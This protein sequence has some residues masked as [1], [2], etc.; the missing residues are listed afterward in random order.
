[1]SNRAPPPQPVVLPQIKLFADIEHGVPSPKAE[2][3][4]SSDEFCD[5]AAAFASSGRSAEL[6]HM[7]LGTRRPKRGDAEPN[8]QRGTLGGQRDRPSSQ[9]QNVGSNK[10]V[11]QQQQQEWKEQVRARH[12]SE[13]EQMQTKTLT[14][15][16]L[17]SLPMSG[18]TLQPTT[19]A[20]TEN[21]CTS[22]RGDLMKTSQLKAWLRNRY[23]GMFSAAAKKRLPGGAATATTANK[24]S[25][26]CS[27]LH[28]ESADVDR[29]VGR[30][31]SVRNPSEDVEHRADADEVEDIGAEVG[32]ASA[33]KRLAGPLSLMRACC[34]SGEMD[35]EIL[36]LV[37]GMII[38]WWDTAMDVLVVV[39]LWLTGTTVPAALATAFVSIPILA[40]AA[41]M[42]YSIWKGLGNSYVTNLWRQFF[43]I[44][45]DRETG[46]GSKNI[47]PR[48]GS[49]GVGSS[50]SGR[51]SCSGSAGHHHTRGLSA[52]S[53]AG[54]MK[55]TLMR[56]V[57]RHP[58]QQ[59][60]SGS[61]ARPSLS[62]VPEEMMEAGEGTSSEL[63]G[64]AMTWQ[65]S[66][67]TKA[68]GR[69]LQSPGSNSCSRSNTSL[70]LRRRNSSAQMEGNSFLRTLWRLTL[71]WVLLLL[72]PVLLSLVVVVLDLCT[73]LC[74][75]KMKAAV[76]REGKY[77]KNQRSRFT[78][79]RWEIWLKRHALARHPVRAVLQ[80]VPMIVLQVT[81]LALGTP[82]EASPYPNTSVQA[83][84]AA[85]LTSSLLSLLVAMLEISCAGR[86]YGLSILQGWQVLYECLHYQGCGMPPAE[87]VDKVSSA[88][89]QVQISLGETGYTKLHRLQ[90]F[91]LLNA[92]MSQRSSVIV[93][94]SLPAATLATS[95]ASA[96]SKIV[97]K[98]AAEAS[99]SVSNAPATSA[100]GSTFK[101]SKV[102]PAARRS[103]VTLLAST[104]DALR[105]LVEAL[106]PSLPAPSPQPRLSAISFNPRGASKVTPYLS[107][108]PLQCL[109]LPPPLQDLWLVSQPPQ[110]PQ[111]EIHLSLVS[112]EPGPYQGLWRRLR[113]L[114]S[115]MMPLKCLMTV[116]I[117]DTHMHTE[118]VKELCQGLTNTDCAVQTLVLSDTGMMST[119]FVALCHALASNKSVTSLDLSSGKL[120]PGGPEALK[121]MLMRN[122]GL[123]E[124]I[125]AY[126]GLSSQDAADIMSGASYNRTLKRLDLSQN[127]ISDDVPLIYLLEDEGRLMRQQLRAQ[128]AAA[129]GHAAVT[130][131][132]LPPTLG[133]GLPT[134]ENMPR[135]GALRHLD[136]SFNWIQD[137]A[138]GWLLLILEFFPALTHL[139]LNHNS[140]SGPPASPLLMSRQDSSGMQAAWHSGTS[141][142]LLMK[143]LDV[144]EQAN[145]DLG[146][147]FLAHLLLHPQGRNNMFTGLIRGVKDIEML[148]V[149]G[150]DLPNWFTMAGSP[151]RPPGLLA[152]KPKQ[153]LVRS[154]SATLSVSRRVSSGAHTRRTSGLTG[155]AMSGPPTAAVMSTTVLSSTN[156]SHQFTP[157]ASEP[158]PL[159]RRLSS[160]EESNVGGGGA[161]TLMGRLIELQQLQK[162]GLS[163]TMMPSG[164]LHDVEEGRE[165]ED[166]DTEKQRSS[167]DTLDEM[168][169][170]GI[171]L[172]LE[173]EED[174]GYL[175]TS[176]PSWR[177]KSRALQR[178]GNTNSP[179]DKDKAKGSPLTLNSNGVDGAVGETETV[180]QAEDLQSPLMLQPRMPEQKRKHKH[181]EGHEAADEDIDVLIRESKASRQQVGQR[182]P[183]LSV[184][185]KWE[186][187]LSLPGAVLDTNDKAWKRLPKGQQVAILYFFF[188]CHSHVLVT[189]VSRSAREALE[190]EIA[191]N[192]N[193]TVNAVPAQTEKP[194]CRESLGQAIQGALNEV[195]AV[196]SAASIALPSP[197]PTTPPYSSA[198]TLNP[199][200]TST[201]FAARPETVH[202]FSLSLW[203]GNNGSHQPV[204]QRVVGGDMSDVERG[205]MMLAFED[206]VTESMSDGAEGFSIEL[207]NKR[208][209]TLTTNA[210]VGMC[211]ELQ[212][213]STS[214]TGTYSE[215]FSTHVQ[216]VERVGK[217]DDQSAITLP[218]KPY[219]MEHGPSCKQ[220]PASMKIGGPL[221]GDGDSNRDTKANPKSERRVSWVEDTGHDGAGGSSSLTLKG[222]L[223]DGGLLVI[224]PEGSLHPHSDGDHKS[225]DVQRLPAP[226]AAPAAAFG[227]FSVVQEGDGL[228]AANCMRVWPNSMTPADPGLPPSLDLPPDAFQSVNAVSYS[229]RPII[230][231]A[232]ESTS[233]LMASTGSHAPSP[234]DAPPPTQHA[235]SSRA[236]SAQHRLATCSGPIADAST[237]HSATQEVEDRRDY[238]EA[239][240]DITLAA[241]HIHDEYGT[242][243]LGPYNARQNNCYPCTA[244]HLTYPVSA[245]LVSP[246]D[247]SSTHPISSGALPTRVSPLL[248]RTLTAGNHAA[249][250]M[251][252]PNMSSPALAAQVPHPHSHKHQSYN[253]PTLSQ[254]YRE[255]P[256]GA[257][258][259]DVMDVKVGT[260]AVRESGSPVSA[261]SWQCQAAH[262]ESLMFQ[263]AI[264]A[265]AQPTLFTGFP[266]QPSGSAFSGLASNKRLEFSRQDTSG[267]PL[268][269]GLAQYPLGTMMHTVSM[270]G[271]ASALSSQHPLLM[272]S[273]TANFFGAGYGRV[274]ALLYGGHDPSSL[275][276]RDPAQVPKTGAERHLRHA[277]SS[278]LDRGSSV[279]FP[280]SHDRLADDQGCRGYGGGGGQSAPVNAVFSANEVG[281]GGSSSSVA[282]HSGPH[283]FKQISHAPLMQR[284]RA[285]ILI[286][287]A[288]NGPA[289]RMLPRALEL[290]LLAAVHM[291]LS[292]SLM[293]S[294]Y[295]RGGEGSADYGGLTDLPM[296][297]GNVPSAVSTSRS[298]VTSVV[299]PISSVLQHAP[300]Q[301][302]L[303]PQ[304]YHQPCMGQVE[305]VMS[306]RQQNNKTPGRS[307][308]PPAGTVPPP[309]PVVEVLLRGLNERQVQQVEGLMSL[310]KFLQKCHDLKPAVEY[311]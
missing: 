204:A 58:L 117:K 119:S 35:L 257:T 123:K 251:G 144:S 231:Y 283:R 166:A 296:V 89:A 194:S 43:I 289:L 76:S 114:L 100:P 51:S 301:P 15:Q 163:D 69:A 258:P 196:P 132:P 240:V 217:A 225:F 32:T 206:E 177:E 45:W 77:I 197:L 304:Q 153:L 168:A 135:S 46:G 253:S 288:E 171:G 154:S 256:S 229:V 33:H 192:A 156:V 293:P 2:H 125:L 104:R 309:L 78:T 108:P 183:D 31:P 307:E 151:G 271:A 56:A 7:F 72:C 19:V 169:G 239:S 27:S 14:E 198:D 161:S 300:F 147:H 26:P 188:S 254:L 185:S 202:G 187:R 71:A 246:E 174:I 227:Q 124:V 244:G 149:R 179:E 29:S 34:G 99:H 83:I 203:G 126:T 252:P 216:C 122:N 302:H 274:I 64:S 200:T 17:P 205:L 209:D 145:R 264:A 38:L 131:R 230:P 250:I 164:A 10:T 297:G 152:D 96:A 305:S 158:L 93:A 195:P 224:E 28:L 118:C 127:H 128:A 270:F 291:G 130:G 87:W 60:L 129:A 94:N 81:L 220:G 226:A 109:L 74:I 180:V 238:S 287:S 273:G 75:A 37:V 53:V 172:G 249:A 277:D 186:L 39:T 190:A 137:N 222:C 98:L 134:E 235:V 260:S 184:P 121:G 92:A 65:A 52:S 143:V 232:Q 191:V 218:G 176:L 167:K 263:P 97:S 155:A 110:P 86:Q 103:Q 140:Y 11:L 269:A 116:V 5:A 219:T 70:S 82:G 286:G 247:R 21:S 266:W 133:S 136:L 139:H 170:D 157:G 4:A 142:N 268:S 165:G 66:V 311:Y 211:D 3:E 8:I 102:L 228:C 41:T 112:F 162:E 210:N 107:P 241:T 278:S 80:N 91:C 181:N 243:D 299:P 214:K 236:L 148:D 294:D 22:G 160:G 234:I 245:V 173:D 282:L 255:S 62:K 207:I 306:V 275:M 48:R 63:Q 208:S 68:H 290:P 9:Q 175:T 215:A 159:L 59:Q 106:P 233:I 212:S 18:G 36:R 113:H 267:S 223:K 308:Q 141:G 261:T 259:N 90:R 298:G 30:G 47:L 44:S 88:R 1:M 105:R 193:M 189:N 20:A 150:L 295:S 281:R 13:F 12:K 85:S 73:V 199:V 265:N 95:T 6:R 146:L 111:Q 201:G 55:A 57:T 115:V 138:A 237:A 61:C 280:A 303:S 279:Q 120:G 285:V 262:L 42:M 221:I 79:A 276:Q 54:M 292:S 40:S 101:A 213:P 50:H 25:T 16:S 84:L 182:Y 67:P 49:S 284:T 272:S 242:Y 23:G 178:Q 248:R 310:V 24:L